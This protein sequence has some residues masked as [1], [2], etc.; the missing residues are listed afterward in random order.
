M[1]VG[2]VGL[3]LIGGSMAKAYKRAGHTVFAFD[4]DKTMLSFSQLENVVDEELNDENISKCDLIIIA[5]Y[6]DATIEYLKEKASKFSKNASVIDCCGTKQK[7]CEC[8][9]ELSEKYG[10]TFY[11]GHPMAGTHNSGYK[12]SSA[13]LFKDAPMVIV[14]KRYDDIEMFDKAKQ[15]LSPCRFGSFSVTT[16]IE[17]DKTIAF[18]SQM[19]HI[20][21]N[22][23]IKSPNAKVHKGF[24]A[25]SYKDLTRVAWL[26]PK[27]WTELFFENK[28][29]LIYELE[30]LI[31][32]L[33][34][35]KSSLLDD[36]KDKMIKLLDEG[37]KI[38]EEV[39]GNDRNQC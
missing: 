14:P 2:I 21:S 24:S 23:F 4:I 37:R 27:M 9:F 33:N 8:G 10:F 30:T 39:D 12:F 38:K 13:D 32:N 5:L 15:L 26:N 25:G 17:H 16:A 34:D 6:P 35:Y 11:G 20:I 22:G 29:H 18:T 36:D 19:P 7:I 31:A 1:I 28:E 3:G